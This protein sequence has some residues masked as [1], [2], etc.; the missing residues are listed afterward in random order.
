MTDPGETKD[1][2]AGQRRAYFGLRDALARWL[3]QS[4]GKGAADE[5]VRRAREAE[6]KLRSLGYIE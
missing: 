1:V 3:G 4:E 6:Q 5:S 2:L